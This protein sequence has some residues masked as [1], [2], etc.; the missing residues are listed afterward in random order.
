M[1]DKETYGDKDTHRPLVAISETGGMISFNA[2]HTKQ[3]AKKWMK[4]NG[5]QLEGKILFA[6]QVVVLEA[7]ASVKVNEID[8]KELDNPE[9]N[10]PAKEGENE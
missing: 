5:R 10:E 6:R 1:E 9:N 4:E 3:D 8:W 2:G 7:K